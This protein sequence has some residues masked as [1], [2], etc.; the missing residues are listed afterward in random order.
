MK[1]TVTVDCSKPKKIIKSSKSKRCCFRC[2]RDS[3]WVAECYA[4]KHVDGTLIKDDDS[5]SDDSDD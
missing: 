5:Y 1:V 2:G 4:K 3:H